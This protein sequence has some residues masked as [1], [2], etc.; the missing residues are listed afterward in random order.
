MAQVRGCHGAGLLK[1]PGPAPVES[2]ERRFAVQVCA[3]KC[4][5]STSQRHVGNLEKQFHIGP[6]VKA[7]G[8][9]IGIT[10]VSHKDLLKRNRLA[11]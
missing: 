7:G 4:E 8:G 1:V 6:P 9:E 3:E 10:T 11:I 5:K 2:A